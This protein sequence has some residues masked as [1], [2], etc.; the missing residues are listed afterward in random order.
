[1]SIAKQLRHAVRLPAFWMSLGLVGLGIVSNLTNGQAQ[2]GTVNS[3][4]SA[5]MPAAKLIREGTQIVKRRA[6]CRSVADRLSIDLGENTQP[7]I[8]LENLAAQRVLKAILDDAGDSAWIV[9]GQVTEF[10]DHNFI[11]LDRVVREARR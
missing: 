11:L 6:T 1:M 8:A 7:L 4:P 10:Q 5:N 3:S 9:S 2:E